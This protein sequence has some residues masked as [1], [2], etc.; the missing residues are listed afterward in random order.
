MPAKKPKT[1]NANKGKSSIEKKA[2]SRSRA[3]KT[4]DSVPLMTAQASATG[5]RR[6]KSGSMTRTNRFTNIDEGMVPFNYSLG[7]YG[8]SSTNLDVRDTVILCQKAYYNFSVCR[9]TID[10]MTELSVSDIYLTGGSKKSKAFFNAFFK[11]INLK[12]LLDRLRS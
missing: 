11:K 8:K 4:V 2:T 9:N 6:N 3:K 12:S 5:T 7:A 10:L 1:T